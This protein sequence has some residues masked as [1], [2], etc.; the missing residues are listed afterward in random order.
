MLM[1]SMS[2]WALV[3]VATLLVLVILPFSRGTN[4]QIV[5]Y[6][7]QLTRPALYFARGTAGGAGA[8]FAQATLISVHF[9]CR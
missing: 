7:P 8:S 1:L 9:L 4:A 3:A 5:R 6:N 2:A